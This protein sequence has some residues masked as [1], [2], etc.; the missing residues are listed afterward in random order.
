M[1]RTRPADR[2]NLIRISVLLF[3][4]LAIASFA[5]AFAAD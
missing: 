4:V 3:S 5:L 1:L 2:T